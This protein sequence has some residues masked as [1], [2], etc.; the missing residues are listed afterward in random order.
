MIKTKAFENKEKLADLLGNPP[1]RLVKESQDSL[2]HLAEGLRVGRFPIVFA[3]RFSCGKSLLIN[4]LFLQEDLL[5]SNINPSTARNM[6]IRYG[7]R[8]R[9][10][11]QRDELESD[12]STETETEVIENPIMEQIREYTNRQGKYL[13]DFGR[14]ILELPH[15][16]ILQQGVCLVDTV[17]TED[18]DDKY[19]EQTINSIR[20]AAAVIFITDA[21]QQLP[22]SEAEFLKKQ[23]DTG[24]R[25]FLVANKI[26]AKENEEEREII[27]QD[28]RERAS[29]LFASSNIRADDRVFMVSAKTGDGLKELREG[30][31]RFIARD[32]ARELVEQAWEAAENLLVP[33]IKGLEEEIDNVRQKKT[34][35]EAELEEKRQKLEQLQDGLQEQQQKIDMDE[36]GLLDFAQQE[37][38]DQLKKA[39]DQVLNQL[40]GHMIHR[41]ELARLLATETQSA[42]MSAGRAIQRE[43]QTLFQR[44]L[45][46][47]MLTNDHEILEN[48]LKELGLVDAAQNIAPILKTGGI[49]S[50]GWGGYVIASAAISGSAQA[51]NA[52]FWAT[53]L[54]PIQSL[55]GG[56]SA[57]GAAASTAAVGGFP[58][59]VGGGAVLALA[60]AAHNVLKDVKSRKTKT[61]TL[62][63]FDQLSL[64]VKADI[65]NQVTQQ[66]QTF[67]EQLIEEVSDKRSNLE[68]ILRKLDPAEL[69]Q[70]LASLEEARQAITSYRQE[71]TVLKME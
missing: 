41:N 66:L 31:I 39:R 62:S 52:G 17:G 45:R 56:T 1:E 68:N 16:E 30:L 38:G 61:L 23:L 13:D 22:L 14:F 11:M 42:L 21:R 35:N 71:L 29:K 26:D 3:G 9:L 8:S 58:L 44:R 33:A 32:R 53:L 59:I 46:K 65:R 12:R 25:L 10:F 27:R 7:K 57:A 55:V 28:V 67:Q 43:I 47:L 69:E 51:A 4:R 20:E 6:V 34:G 5:P 49:A 36:E 70:K 48:I 24:K 64:K 63:Y 54:V 37:V 19:V 60:Y 18:I 40:Y 2:K 50:M 15:E